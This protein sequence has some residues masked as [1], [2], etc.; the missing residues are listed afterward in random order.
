MNYS[1]RGKAQSYSLDE[2]NEQWNTLKHF[3]KRLVELSGEEENKKIDEFLD[4]IEEILLKDSCP[5]RFLLNLTSTKASA[6]QRTWDSLVLE[7]KEKASESSYAYLV[8][9]LRAMKSI[10]EVINYVKRGENFSDSENA[11]EKNPKGGFP[12]VFGI[13]P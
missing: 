2:V 1:P 11:V 4:Y 10:D 8:N 13:S 7:A 12:R 3:H 5:P 9:K 6:V